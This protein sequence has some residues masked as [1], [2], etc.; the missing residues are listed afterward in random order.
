MA[1]VGISVDQDQPKWDSYVKE[2]KLKGIQL[3]AGSGNEL[4]KAYKVDGIPRY[5]LIDKAGNLI[6]ADSPRPSDPKL[7]ALL[8]EWIKK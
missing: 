4:S 3:Y 1:L 6:S 2:K 5:I 8:E 7:K